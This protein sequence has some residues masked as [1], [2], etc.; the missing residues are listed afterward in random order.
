MQLQFAKSTEFHI[1][2]EPPPNFSTGIKD[3]NMFSLARSGQVF[4]K[5]RF[6]QGQTGFSLPQPLEGSIM[7]SRYTKVHHAEAYWSRTG[8]C[9]S[10]AAVEC[11]GAEGQAVILSIVVESI[12]QHIIETKEQFNTIAEVVRSEEGDRRQTRS[13]RQ[14]QAQPLCSK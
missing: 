2:G 3:E 8:R 12:A 5:W 10:S 9:R 11:D 7:R 6:Q 1:E 14:D 4:A 13:E